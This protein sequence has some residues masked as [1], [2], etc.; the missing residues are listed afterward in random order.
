MD[1]IRQMQIFIQVMENGNFTKAAEA[2]AIPRSTVSTEIQQLEDRLKTQLFLRTTRK[3]VPTQDGQQFL[4]IARDIVDAVTSAEQ[5]FLQTELQVSGRLRVDMPSRI[6]SKIV[7]PALPG[8]LRQYP[9]LTVDLSAS[10]RIVDLVAD[11]VDCALRLGV[12]DNS[13]LVCRNL[14]EVPF[15][16]CTSPSYLV[17]NGV[18]ETLDDLRTH[19]MVNY[20]TR[21]PATSSVLDF[22]RDGSVRT[23]EVPSTVTV[24]GAEA[25]L[26]AALSG[27]G[28]IQVPAY[29]VRDH[30]KAG[31]LVEVL[32]DHPVPS[33][34]LSFL[35]VRRRNLAPRVRVFLHWL[36]TVLMQ[37]GVMTQVSRG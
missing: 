30:L 17:R 12:L 19:S 16:T 2:L 5:M 14:G 7:L 37:N 36:E 6:G 27:L 8:L 24:D 35:Y 25:Y 22:L 34:P 4:A 23:V 33:L 10:D 13:E 20:A 1:R 15:V 3:V 29:D 11:S 26:A 32:P 18:P 28:L 31:E 9:D 21:L